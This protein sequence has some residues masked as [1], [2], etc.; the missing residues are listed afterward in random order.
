[1]C[2]GPHHTRQRGARA[3][4]GAHRGGGAHPKGQRAWGGGRGHVR[5]WGYGV[6][7]NVRSRVLRGSWGSGEGRG[8]MGSCE[9][10]GVVGVGV[11]S[12][13]GH[14]VMGSW[15][16]GSCE[17]TGVEGVVGVGV[18]SCEDHGVMGCEVMGVKGVVGV[19]VGSCEGYGV[20]GR[21]G[22]WALRG[23]WGWGRV[24]GLRGYGM[25]G[26]RGQS[27]QG[28]EVRVGSEVTAGSWVAVTSR[29]VT[30]GS[31]VTPLPPHR[32][33]RAAPRCW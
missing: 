13:E 21:V 3:R 12:G 15:D 32:P 10:M 22:S 11:G 7:G 33:R 4:V 5:S 16:V 17:V 20:W 8:V 1:M 6:W 2:R 28:W 23:S 29:G 27:P 19:M 25:W 24:M 9:V 14:G 30:A 18:G 26:H 31:E